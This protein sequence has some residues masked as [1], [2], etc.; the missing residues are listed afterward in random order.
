MRPLRNV[1]YKLSCTEQRREGVAAYLWS[2]PSK[3]IRSPHPL[4]RKR[5]C[6]PP[7]T[8]RRG[9]HSEGV[10]GWGDPIRTTG[11]KGWKGWHSVLK[12]IELCTW[13]KKYHADN[14]FRW[15]K[16][17]NSVE[18]CFWT[19]LFPDWFMIT[20]ESRLSSR[21]IM[22]SRTT[23]HLEKLSTNWA[24]YGKSYQKLLA[25]GGTWRTYTVK[26]G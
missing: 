8:Q 26:K 22:F 12:S 10:M 5:V 3:G 17:K 13:S 1:F 20:R 4:P 18:I 11:Q 14:L 9:Q 21:K 25:R 19:L 15:F 6:L 16:Q 7:W 23:F 2:V 24:E